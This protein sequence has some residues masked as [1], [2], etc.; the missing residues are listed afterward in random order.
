MQRLTTSLLIAVAINIGLLMMMHLMTQSETHYQVV[1]SPSLLDFIRLD[2]ASETAV[3]TRQLPDKPPPPLPTPPPPPAAMATPSVS[4]L[5][6]PDVVAPQIAVPMTLTGGPFL[7]KVAAEAIDTA[8][9]KPTTYA[10]VAPIYRAPPRYPRLA[11]TRGIEGQ[12]RV[13]FT[14]NPQGQ[15]QD[16][17]IL[18]A[19]PAGVFEKAALRAIKKW[20]FAPQ[21][22]Q[23]KPTST[24]AAVTIVFKMPR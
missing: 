4:S 15:V 24:L 17:K 9:V 21:V 7:G 16:P 10:N 14:I 23:D 8:S 1:E 6:T 13:A 11:K 5:P 20:K 2:T 22:E 3:K 12:V 19:D 18:A